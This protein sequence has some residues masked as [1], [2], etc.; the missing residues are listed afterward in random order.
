MGN[1]DMHANAKGLAVACPEEGFVSI[2]Y[3]LDSSPGK[4]SEQ[5]IFT[6]LSFWG[7]YD[8]PELCQKIV[9]DQTPIYLMVDDEEVFNLELVPSFNSQRA[10][11]IHQLSRF[12][13]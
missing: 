11:L 6:N 10:F 7:I 2:R 13:S 1:H 9:S 12:F 4:W 8:S 5:K 3:E